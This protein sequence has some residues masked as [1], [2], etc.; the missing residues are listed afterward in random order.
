MSLLDGSE[1][2]AA[3]VSLP[4]WQKEGHFVIVHYVASTNIARRGCPDN[5]K[6]V[7]ESLTHYYYSL[8]EATSVGEERDTL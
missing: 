2:L 8:P 6:A 3:L 1:N 4:D 7:V 5:H